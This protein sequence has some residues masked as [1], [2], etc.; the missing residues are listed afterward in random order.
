MKKWLA[1]LMSALLV[2]TL[3]SCRDGGRQTESP[4]TGESVQEELPA[5]VSDTAHPERYGGVLRFSYTGMG[6]TFDAYGQSSW[7]TYVWAS[8]VFE[9]PLALGDDGKFYPLVCDFDLEDDSKTIRLRVRDGVKFS[10]GTP[11]TVDD[12]YA[13]LER[14]SEMIAGT[15]QYL[16]DL[17]DHY[18]NDGNELT[19][20]MKEYN[21]NTMANVF[22]Q[23]R[24]Y[25]GI[26]P[27]RI[28]EKYGT[29]LIDDMQDVIGTGPYK[30][31]PARSE[32]GVKVTFIRNEHYSV[33]TS[34]PE[35][36]GVA[37]P[38][39]QYLD[40]MVFYPIDNSNTRLMSLEGGQLD[41]IECNNEET[42][43]TA[44]APLK[45]YKMQTT[46]SNSCAYMFFNL[47]SPTKRPI[48]DVNLRKAIASCFDYAEL[49]Y[50]SYGNLGKPISGPIVSGE[51]YHSSF[52][53]SDYYGVNDLEKARSFLEASDYK[54]EELLFIGN[55][56]LSI[57]TEAMKKI[58]IRASYSTPDNATMVAYA[59][60]PSQDWDVIYR[61]NPLAISSPADI[62][63]TMYKNWGNERAEQLVSDLG[64][65]VVNS[66]E[67]LAIWRELD[68]LM[69]AEVPYI[70]FSYT[71]MGYAMDS[72]LELN[73]E[74][75]FRMYWNAYWKTPSEH[76]NWE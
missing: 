33:S 46:M 52:E 28:V 3:A 68:A 16:F 24:P 21:I 26:M 49:I 13:S 11:V 65:A 35:G 76:V 44:L 12:V 71:V 50:A 54:G 40:G 41:I 42:F 32:L 53:E 8:N 1:V 60:D 63:S 15:K 5:Y 59:N 29:E 9:A 39:Y 25:C 62:H 7:T 45:R 38:K 64:N 73:N 57:V 55:A 4:S 23:C 72:D 10:D 20:Y 48:H 43:D 67:S 30:I 27:K 6:S 58:G 69:V 17:L 36:N 70:I 19:F 61:T 75:W 47:S 66:E 18:D 2:L 74:S 37:S 31:D 51:G 34:S 14:S 56:Y 22:A